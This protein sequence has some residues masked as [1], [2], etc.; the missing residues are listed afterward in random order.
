MNLARY[1][2]FIFSTKG[3]QIFIL[4]YKRMC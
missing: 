4:I 1:M 3:K 2:Y